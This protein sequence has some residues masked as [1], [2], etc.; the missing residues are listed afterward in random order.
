MLKKEKNPGLNFSTDEELTYNYVIIAVVIVN[1]IIDTAII[2]V[3]YSNS[4]TE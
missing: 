4:L 3:C 1:I 2:L